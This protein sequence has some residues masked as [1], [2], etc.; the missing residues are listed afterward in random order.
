MDSMI[1]FE[2]SL[3]RI[4]ST[5]KKFSEEEYNLLD[6]KIV[7]LA[8]LFGFEFFP[9]QYKICIY[10]ID[11]YTFNNCEEGISKNKYAFT[12]CGYKVFV[13]EYESIEKKCCREAYLKVIIHECVHILQGYYSKILPSRYVWLYET[14]ACY[15]SNQKN[16][17]LP[18][19]TISWKKFSDEFYSFSGNYGIAYLYGKYLF[20][21]FSKSEILCLLKKPENFSNQCER[22]YNKMCINLK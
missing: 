15:L 17:I 5:D 3:I 10:I 20:E 6:N 12:S 18:K 21:N 2:N 4:Y 19:E 16:S 14:I 8:S 1:F 7:K 9:D 13:L 22:L 11:Q